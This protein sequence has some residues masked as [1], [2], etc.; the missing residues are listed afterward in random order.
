MCQ[1]LKSEPCTARSLRSLEAQRTLRGQKK[2]SFLCGL[3][4]SAVKYYLKLR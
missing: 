2:I 3:T 1:A 4:G